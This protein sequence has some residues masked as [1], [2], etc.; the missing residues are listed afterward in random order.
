MPTK[1]DYLAAHENNA[2]ITR[3][4]YVTVAPGMD[5]VYQEKAAE[6]VAV[7]GMGREAANAL[8]DHGTAEFPMLA[9][10]VGIEAETLFDIAE[11][12][13]EKAEAFASIAGGIERIRL[14]GKKA[15]SSA[16]TDEEAK[17]AFESITWP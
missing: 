14:A 1:A 8:P 7:V 6:A 17:A 11:I 5:L 2:A 13:S 16:E 15:I 10:S 3:S 4:R 12:V 9:A